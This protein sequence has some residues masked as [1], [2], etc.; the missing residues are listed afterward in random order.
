[1]KNL[2]CWTSQCGYGRD[3][4]IFWWISC[5]KGGTVAYSWGGL[6]TSCQL[7]TGQLHVSSRS[8]D[9]KMNFPHSW[10]WLGFDCFCVISNITFKRQVYPPKKDMEMVFS[11]SV[12][13][14][15]I[16]LFNLD[17]VVCNVNNDY[18]NS[19]DITELCITVTN[20]CI[21]SLNA[22]FVSF[23]W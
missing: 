21:P 22:W 16:T 18:L 7:R 10:S 9:I 17:D 5:L 6:H 23:E 14:E 3:E 11:L 19:V 13:K 12:H 1:M 20:E 4:H 2:W 15:W 8:F